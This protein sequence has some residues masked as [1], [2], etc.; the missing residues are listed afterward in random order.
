MEC[1]I[2]SC[3]KAQTREKTHLCP[4]K[5][6][7]FNYPN[8]F[9]SCSHPEYPRKDSSWRD[10]KYCPLKNDPITVVIDELAHLHS[11]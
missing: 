3:E 7:T 11:K 9:T 2:F 6:D 8:K 4:F 5:D 1:I 10:F